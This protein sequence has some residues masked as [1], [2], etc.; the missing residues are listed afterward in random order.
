LREAKKDLTQHVLFNVSILNG[1]EEGAVRGL[2]IRG[3]GIL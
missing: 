2:E 1:Q 3:K